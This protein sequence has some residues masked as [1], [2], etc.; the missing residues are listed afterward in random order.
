M[1]IQRSQDR[2]NLVIFR[3][4]ATA[5]IIP[6]RQV[7]YVKNLAIARGKRTHAGR[8][9]IRLRKW[10]GVL[11]A[12]ARRIPFKYGLQGLLLSIFNCRSTC[13]DPVGKIP[14]SSGL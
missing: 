13:P 7:P 14:T 4:Y 11:D 9:R 12:S 6:L 8:D 5:G 1:A 10:T 2:S 3:T